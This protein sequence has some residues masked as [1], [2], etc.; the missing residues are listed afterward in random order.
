MKNDFL[1]A[2]ISKSIIVRMRFILIMH[3][4]VAG[5]VM[6]QSEKSPA[7]MMWIPGGEFTMGLDASCQQRGYCGDVAQDAPLQR[8]RVDGFW[9][10]AT[11]VTNAQFSQFVRATGYVTL[12]E[13]ALSAEDYPDVAPEHLVAGSIVFTPTEKAVDRANAYQW[14]SYVAGANWRHPMGPG[15]NLDGKDREP[16]VH[17]AYEDALA[18]ATWAG[19]RL[20]TEA[21]WEYAARGGKEQRLFPWGHALVQEGK[22][23]ANTYQGQFPIRDG[24]LGTDGFKGIAPVAQYPANAYGLFDMVGNVWEWC[25]DWYHPEAFARSQN[26]TS[27]LVNPQG[28]RASFD[29]A[30]P[31]V[32]KRSMRGGSFLCHESYCSRYLLGSRGK[33]DIS[34]ATNHI[35]FRCVMSKKTSMP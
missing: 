20:P 29:P 30:E 22:H 6:P 1:R 28:P 26:R 27:V 17:V 14:W 34:A 21:E 31:H 2:S 23:R 16:V 3:W 10:D 15:S 35:G 24:D 11:E 33:G 13:K 12:A 9:M 8:V 7:N 5:E 25:A 32:K 19:K 18:Y 4:A